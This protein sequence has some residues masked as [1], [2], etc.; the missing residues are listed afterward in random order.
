[1]VANFGS[2]AVTDLNQSVS[3]STALAKDL[4]SE[5]PLRILGSQLCLPVPSDIIDAANAKATED[6]S[7]QP[8]LSHGLQVGLRLHT[9]LLSVREQMMAN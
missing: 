9:Y 2:K 7:Q 1:M 5:T 4:N 3:N 6:R 8:G